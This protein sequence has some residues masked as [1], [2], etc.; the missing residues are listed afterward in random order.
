MSEN[1]GAWKTSATR[2]ASGD[3][4]RGNIMELMELVRKTR[5]YRRFDESKSIE[6]ATLRDLVELTRFV[7]TGSNMQP[8]KYRLSADPETNAKVF[9]TLAW[10]GYLTDWKGPESGER[11]TGYIIMLLDP[12]IRKEPGADHGIAAQTIMLGAVERGF[13]GCMFGSIRK[14]ELKAT[15]AIPDPLEILL[16]LA[17]GVPVERMVLEDVG[18]DGSIKYYR[19]Q[20]RAHHVPKRLLDDI[21][22]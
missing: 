12:E 5:S 11:P 7:A 16:V 8:L 22:V 9:A 21:I 18:A 3:K 2:T 20:D 17:L 1:T 10:A 13:G 19:D 14:K 4:I 15:L 6:M